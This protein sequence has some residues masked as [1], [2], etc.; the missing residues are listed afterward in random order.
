MLTKAIKP[1]LRSA[2]LG[3]FPFAAAITLFS[4]VSQ[5]RFP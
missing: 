4:A 1:F 5:A 3:K 2:G